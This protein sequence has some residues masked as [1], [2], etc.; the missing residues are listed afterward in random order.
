M[1][2]PE[3]HGRGRRVEKVPT[4]SVLVNKFSSFTFFILIISLI[5]SLTGT[6]MFKISGREY[7]IIF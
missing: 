7:N 2:R 4:P 6:V 5:C 3:V 1:Y